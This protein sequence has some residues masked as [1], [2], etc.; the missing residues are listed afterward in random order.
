MKDEM[1]KDHAEMI[2]QENAAK[3]GYEELMAAKEKEI[4]AATKAIEEKLQ[5]VGD[6]AVEIV[7]MKND[8]AE[9][10]EALAEDKNFLADLEKNCD[11]KKK[12]WAERQKTRSEEILAIQETIKILNDD[13]ALELFKKTLSSPSLIQTETTQSELK[14]K[15]LNLIKGA[16]RRN[17]GGALDLIA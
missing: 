11:L 9:T 14:E 15:A 8:L 4:A 1:E 7:T 13:D 16:R 10:Q 3:A 5:R 12:E 2:A 6:L 17:H